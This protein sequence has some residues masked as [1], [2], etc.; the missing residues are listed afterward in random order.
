MKVFYKH[1][2]A[3]CCVPGKSTL[4]GVYSIKEK[5]SL[6]NICEGDDKLFLL[7]GSQKGKIPNFPSCHLTVKIWGLITDD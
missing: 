7:S 4:W 6:F 1:D 5:G 2:S 3:S